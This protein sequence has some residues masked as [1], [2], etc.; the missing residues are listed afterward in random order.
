VTAKTRAP[1]IELD[2]QLALVISCET[3]VKVL[4]YLVERT[5]SPKEIGDRLKLKTATASHHVQK[6]LRMGLIELI[7]EKEVH[8]AIQHIYRAVV[9]PIVSDV[10][11]DKLSITERQR[12]SIWIVQLILVDAAKSFA[13]KLFDARSNNHLSRT[14]MVVDEEGL[15]EVAEIQRRAL[16]ETIQAEANSAERRLRSGEP[17]INLIAA[18]MCF[19]IPES[20]DGHRR[21]SPAGSP[22]VRQRGVSR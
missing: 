13:A 6:L 18:M 1:E 2:D 9:R 21:S 4:I 22:A 17:G 3:T 14:P 15:V 8:G 7:E 11:W 5:G 19:E 16:I 12:Y 10:E 20:T